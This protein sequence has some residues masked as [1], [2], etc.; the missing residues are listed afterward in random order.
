MLT[1]TVERDTIYQTAKLIAGKVGMKCDGNTC[2]NCDKDCMCLEV[3]QQIHALGYKQT[4]SHVKNNMMKTAPMQ[5]ISGELAKS[6][7]LCRDYG[8][9]DQDC[10]VRCGCCGMCIPHDIAT[11]LVQNGYRKE[12]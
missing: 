12:N 6:I 5:G 2:K 9:N 3:A 4:K 11:H 10:C 7:A 1:E 8:C